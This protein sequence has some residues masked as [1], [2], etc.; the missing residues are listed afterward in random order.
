MRWVLL[1]NVLQHFREQQLVF[2]DPLHW[3]QQV[4]V[5]V[6]LMTEFFLAHLQIEIVQVI[7]N[8]SKTS[9][10]QLSHFPWLETLITVFLKHCQI[11]ILT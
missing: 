1:T 4:R 3:F 11:T 6:Q 8:N 2:G 10:F 9:I 7:H 5:Q